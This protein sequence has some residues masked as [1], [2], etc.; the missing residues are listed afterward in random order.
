MQWRRTLAGGVAAALAVGFGAPGVTW[1]DDAEMRE[2]VEALQQKVEALEN[3]LADQEAASGDVHRLEGEVVTLRDDIANWQDVAVD[4]GS[5]FS[6]S[7]YVETSYNYNFN[8]PRG[9]HPG[10]QGFG[11]GQNRLRIFDNNSSTFEL[12]AARLTLENTADEVG[13]AGFRVDLTVGTQADLI[14]SGNTGAG[15]DDIDLTQA[16][17][18]YIADVG[19]GLEVKAGKFVTWIGYE[20][21]EAHD[22][23]NYSRAMAFGYTIPFAHTGVGVSYQFNDLVRYSQYLVN[24]WDNALD[25]NDAKSTGGQLVLTPSEDQTGGIPV[26]FYFNWIAGQEGP[27]GAGDD[28]RFVLDWIIT[29]QLNDQWG[30]ALNIDYGESEFEDAPAMDSDWFAIAGYATYQYTD[31]L[32]FAMRLEYFSDENGNRTGLVGAVPVDPTFLP[33][34][35]LEVWEITGTVNYW[36]TDNLLTRAELRYDSA[37]EDVFLGDGFGDFEDSQFTLGLAATYLF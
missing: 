22:N 5:D 16:Y 20:V 34:E 30:V 19:N 13:D 2:L 29:A 26:E 18:N 1:A 27:G 4:S 3:R 33:G 11:T 12:N 28:S 14:A 15:D 7:G 36:V 21:I 9:P 8:N 23:P 35:D 32:G 24:G 25:E 10:S 31:A 17:V 6:I 37:D